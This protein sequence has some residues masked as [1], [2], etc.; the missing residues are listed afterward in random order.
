MSQLWEQ[1]LAGLRLQVPA[2]EWAHYFEHLRGWMDAGTL[3]IWVDSHVD[4][5]T[6]AEILGHLASAHDTAIRKVANRVKGGQPVRVR[7]ERHPPNQE[8]IVNERRMREHRESESRRLR[9]EC[10]EFRK[11]QIEEYRKLVAEGAPRLRG[12]S[13]QQKQR[14]LQIIDARALRRLEER[15]QAPRP[16]RASRRRERGEPPESPPLWPP[17]ASREPA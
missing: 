2:E 5:R 6:R 4:V 9:A 14:L 10:A 3:Y 8:R 1:C 7:Y 12:T 15:N 13:E 17:D 11:L 16:I